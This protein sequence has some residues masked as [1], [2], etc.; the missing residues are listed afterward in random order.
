MQDPQYVWPFESFDAEN[1]AFA[2]A[3]AELGTDA[4]MRILLQR[5]QQ[6]KDELMAVQQ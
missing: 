3:Q 6:V 1:L 2:Q 5:A 4:D